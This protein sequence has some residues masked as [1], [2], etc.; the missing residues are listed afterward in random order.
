ML[1]L[2]G[3]ITIF[4]GDDRTVEVT[5]EDQDDNAIDITGAAIDVNG[6]QL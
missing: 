1:L 3:E 4:R 2:T 6:G 5:V